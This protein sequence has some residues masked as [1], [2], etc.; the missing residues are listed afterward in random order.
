MPFAATTRDRI[1]NCLGLPVVA[2]RWIEYVQESMDRAANYGGETAIARIE[3]YLTKYETAETT[4]NT[5]AGASALIRA[6][7]LEWEAGKRNS[8]Y[9]TEMMHY[10]NLVLSSLFLAEERESVMVESPYFGGSNVRTN[11][12]SIRR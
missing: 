2:P 4:R 10:R 11:K 12:V 8:G 9:E 5:Q 3:G 1:L 7:V 6:D